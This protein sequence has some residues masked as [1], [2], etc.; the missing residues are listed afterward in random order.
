MNLRWLGPYKPTDRHAD[1]VTVSELVRLRAENDRYCEQ[2][3]DILECGNGDDILDA[4][5][6][7]VRKTLTVLKE[8]E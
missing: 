4:I 2:L 6:K 7:D 5:K 3:E 1:D 8:G